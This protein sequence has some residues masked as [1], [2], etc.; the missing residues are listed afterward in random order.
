MKLYAVFPGAHEWRRDIS[1]YQVV[2]FHGEAVLP[3]PGAGVASHHLEDRDLEPMRLIVNG[4][5]LSDVFMPERSGNLVVSDHVKKQLKPFEEKIAFLPVVLEKVFNLPWQIDGNCIQAADPVV[6]DSAKAGR[7][8]SISKACTHDAA[9]AATL[10]T[11]YEVVTPRHYGLIKR[12]RPTHKFFTKWYKGNPADV[13]LLPVSRALF[14]DF[15]MTG[16]GFPI[17]RD[18]VFG[19]LSP[20]MNLRFFGIKEFSFDQE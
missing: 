20:F 15:P 8:M 6:A 19:A 5:S 17:V 2:M 9:L 12:Y 10:P 14:H 3:R 1:F 13:H 16:A 7:E 18:D 4:F 11:Y